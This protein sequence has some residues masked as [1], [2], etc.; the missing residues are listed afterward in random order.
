[1]RALLAFGAAA[2]CA[3]V[4]REGAGA[5]TSVS[6][7]TRFGPDHVME[8]DSLPFVIGLHVLPNL[9]GFPP[10]P[11][12]RE[13]MLLADSLGV[14]AL[15]VRIAPEG[16]TASALDSLDRALEPYRRD[17]I[18]VLIALGFP[19]AAAFERRASSARYVARRLEEIDRVVRR[20][21]PDYLIPADAPYGVGADVM[22]TLPV[23]W[24][25]DYVTAAA[26][27][28]HRLR[29]ATRVMLASAGAGARDSAL[30][31]WASA[32]GSPV[33][34]PAFEIAAARDGAA[35]LLGTLA[36]ADRWIQAA[37]GS[38]PNWVFISGAPALE[39]EDAQRRAIRHVLAWASARGA[40]EGVVLGDASDYDRLTGFRAANGRL[41]RVTADVATMIANLTAAPAAPPPP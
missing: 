8:R 16:C 31:A 10:S 23:R 12:M 20:L 35:H 41:R 22:G 40:V 13:D 36:T 17:S 1:M 3:L 21:R 32:T 37:G 25:E 27:V 14:T 6:G 28:A 26:A 33:D 7:Y 29:P 38:R 39:G 11:A 19:R 24:W 5:R 9:T 4:V 18:R 30:Y 34:V 15:E 2:M